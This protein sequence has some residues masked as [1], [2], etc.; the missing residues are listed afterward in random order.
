M[1][2]VAQPNFHPAPPVVPTTAVLSPDLSL[3]M[4]AEDEAISG[5][6]FDED[7]CIYTRV[8]EPDDLS[9]PAL[10]VYRTHC[11]LPF[12]HPVAR[13]GIVPTDATTK[14]L[15]VP[16]PC[17]RKEA[18]AS[19]WWKGYYQAELVE[20][21]SL[22]KNGTWRLIPRSEVPRGVNV[23]RDRWAYS[24]KL[25]LGGAANEK[26]KARLTCMGC[27]Q[28]AG[29]D[30][31]ET[32]ASVMNTR[33]F[34]MIL[35]LY[36]SNAEHHMVHWDVSTAFIHAPLEEKVYMKQATGHEVEGKESSCANHNESIAFAELIC[37]WVHA[38]QKADN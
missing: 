29:V 31:T 25:G 9:L 24:D 13:V 1:P 30:Y 2:Q 17:N 36:N 19:P 15:S 12:P 8:L 26:F 21:E 34:R 5:D 33:T 6:P 32:Y 10:L 27:F 18:M 3:P 11:N 28:R 20:M 4:E 38:R 37:R 7:A 14:P 16:A 22:R 23:L 35:Q